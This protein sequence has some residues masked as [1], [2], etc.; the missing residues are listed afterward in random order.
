MIKKISRAHKCHLIVATSQPKPYITLQKPHNVRQTSLDPEF[1]GLT[2]E[3]Q[4]T[5][6][7]DHQFQ[8][9]FVTIFLKRDVVSFILA[10]WTLRLFITFIGGLSFV[11]SGHQGFIGE[12]KP[13][14][15]LRSRRLER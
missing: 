5:S 3:L 1:N 10:Q 6:L 11:I 13:K 4:E 12:P 14:A 8:N 9:Y 7:E 2:I 15:L